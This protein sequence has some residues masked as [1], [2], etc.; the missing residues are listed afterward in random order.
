MNFIA[1]PG[2]RPEN[3]I[4]LYFSSEISKLTNANEVFTTVA[5]GYSKY[6]DILNHS[7]VSSSPTLV[8][9]NRYLS[10]WYI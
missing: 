7:H 8:P 6:S 1:P 3:E 4:P 10:K 5:L 9:L 2:A